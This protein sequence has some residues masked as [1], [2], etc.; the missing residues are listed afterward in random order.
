MQLQFTRYNIFGLSARVFRMEKINLY[1]EKIPIFVVSW[2]SHRII[3]GYMLLL[4]LLL[5]VITICATKWKLW[6]PNQVK[7]SLGY[8]LNIKIIVQSILK[9]KVVGYWLIFSQK[10][11]RL[12][13][14]GSC[15]IW[16]PQHGFDVISQTQDRSKL[17]TS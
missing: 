6:L 4:L 17:T 1:P 2:N 3:L 15:L 10:S 8:V 11:L 9:L 13:F 7:I 5:F 12:M 14:I 16:A